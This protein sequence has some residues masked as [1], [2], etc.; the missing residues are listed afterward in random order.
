[1]ELSDFAPLGLYELTNDEPASVA[2]HKSLVSSLGD[3]NFDMSDGSRMQ[4]QCFARAMGMAYQRKQLEV[5]NAQRLPESVT[6]LMPVLEA[7][8]GLIPSPQDTVA[9]RR[10][11]LVARF[12]VPEQNSA[13]EITEALTRRLG[14]D[15]VAYRPTPLADADI[16]PAAIGDHPMHLA[17]ADAPRKRVT[18]KT[19]ISFVG[20]SQTVGF[21]L[22]SGGALDV[23]D[24]VVFDPG[25]W[26]LA[27]R[28]T[29]EAL[30]GVGAS[31]T[32]TATFTYPHDAGALGVTM[33]YAEWSSSKRHS[34]VVLTPSA[35]LDPE[36][37]RIV[38]DE[39]S[40]RVRASSTWDVVAATVALDE[41]E[42]FQLDEE[43]LDV[44]TLE[45]VT[46]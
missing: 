37:R 3:G 12:K 41:T 18:L 43:S 32:L 17:R 15:F 26:G 11:E 16:V 33:P 30:A 8:Y 40:R 31:T 13:F 29:I 21:T 24:V 34:L 7:R 22:D 2:I 39:M 6:F 36:K 19:A 4:A 5:A 28:V 27:D 44:R 25:H 10:A 20:V 9:A 46:L 42:L 14:D 35:A 1:M 23:G 45:T 38:D